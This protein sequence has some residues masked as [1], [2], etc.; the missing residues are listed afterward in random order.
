MAGKAIAVHVLNGKTGCEAAEQWHWT[1]MKFG[2][3]RVGEKMA[4]RLTPTELPAY[5]HQIRLGGHSCE[6]PDYSA[7]NEQEVICWTTD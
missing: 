6:D 5:W 4:D 2:G 1:S 7:H 3:P